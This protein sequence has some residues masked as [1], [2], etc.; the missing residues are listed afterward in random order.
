MPPT[1]GQPRPKSS[2]NETWVGLGQKLPADGGGALFG[3]SGIL[4]HLQLPAAVQRID[5][6]RREG[7]GCLPE[8]SERDRAHKADTLVRLLVLALGLIAILEKPQRAA[9]AGRRQV[10]KARVVLRDVVG[11]ANELD[12]V[13]TL[14]GHL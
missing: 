1:L 12:G 7:G 3:S 2:V 13:R 8:Q 9:I 10:Q 4:I 14:A 5:V 6:F 11:R